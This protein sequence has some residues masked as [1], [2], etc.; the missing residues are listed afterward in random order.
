[1]RRGS[2]NRVTAREE[3]VALGLLM[4]EAGQGIQKEQK[5]WHDRA[6]DCSLQTTYQSAKVLEIHPEDLQ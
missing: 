1:M 3:E 5:V 2:P 6:T 4:Q